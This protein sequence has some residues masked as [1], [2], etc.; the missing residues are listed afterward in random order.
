M[1]NPS[2]NRTN[3]SVRHSGPIHSRWIAAAF[4]MLH[5]VSS[6]PAM[7]AD[8]QAT[9][10]ELK[11][12]VPRPVGK[13]IERI[14]TCNHWGGEEAYN[15]ERKAQINKQMH[16]LRCSELKQ[17]ERLILKQYGSVPRV[18]QKIYDAKKTYF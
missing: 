4:S 15:E 7:A 5:I 11:S 16:D 3:N 8:S 18:R 17:D 12:G 1:P 13:L 10:N 2:L 14:A 6:A 9:M